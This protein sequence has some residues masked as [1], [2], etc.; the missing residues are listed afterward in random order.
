MKACYISLIFCLL[1][2]FG[3]A[4]LSVN[5]SFI[6]K[7]VAQDAFKHASISA[8]VIEVNSE[9]E[10]LSYRK[11]K[12]L[13]P[14]S[15]LKLLTT[16]S[17]LHY[18]G[19][20][21]QYETTI[22]YDGKILNDGTL[23]GNILINGVGDPTLGSSK[24][25]SIQN[26]PDLIS[27]I[28]SAIESAGIT[29]VSKAVIADESL[30]NSYPISPSWQ[31]NDLGNYYAGGAWGLNV[32]DNQYYVF[33]HQQPTEGMYPK[34]VRYGPKIPN[35]TLENE[36]ETGKPGS[37]DN[38][39]IFG[40]PYDYTKRIIGT[41]PPGSKEFT[42]KGSIPDPPLFM[43]YHVYLSLQKSKIKVDS[44]K[45]VFDWPKAK[46]SQTILKRYAS[47]SMSS[48]VKT[49][50][51]ESHNLYCEALLKTIG[52]EVSGEGSGTAGIKAIQ[53]Y[54]DKLSIDRSGL[55]LEDGSGLSTRNLMS[56]HVMAD[57]LSKI[58]QDIGLETATSYLPRVGAQGTVRSML[59]ESPA[60]GRV[61]A[62]SGSMESVISYSGYLKA[63][64]GKWLSFCIIVNGFPQ[65]NRTMR[66][67]MEQF[68]EAVYINN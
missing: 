37:G 54:L 47:P 58:A 62:K 65:K 28:R 27:D 2:I 4:Q 6:E 24:F 39:Y 12:V 22:G 23:E 25:S 26:F 11:N 5:Q 20:E 42:I 32:N 41:I 67:Y 49:A 48:I 36:V 9:N 45:S 14:A 35:L 1:P 55:R 19:E 66:K 3:E 44:Y 8:S 68:M 51:F 29:C 63:K 21:Y 10:L 38:A 31:W 33:F 64:S 17:A 40:G 52:L 56:S 60:K 59:R 18:L 61:W 53:R 46:P 57:F 43:A 15:S 34:L 50:N 13:I 16:F 7:F 30:F